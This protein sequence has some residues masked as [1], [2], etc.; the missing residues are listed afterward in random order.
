M[1]TTA[2]LAIALLL[3]AL[4][5]FP[6]HQSTCPSEPRHITDD[7]IA[8]LGGGKLYHFFC[9]EDGHNYFY[10]ISNVFK[11]NVLLNGQYPVVGSRWR[12]RTSPPPGPH[13]FVV[14]GEPG[15]I[16]R[17]TFKTNSWSHETITP[18]GWST[19]NREE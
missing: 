3:L 7:G 9:E 13:Y 4:P 17:Y 18:T 1:K 2:T 5:A 10:Y 14:E 16:Y 12:I 6:Q 11:E 19:G 8:V 15:E